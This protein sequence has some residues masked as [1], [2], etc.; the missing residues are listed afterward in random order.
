MQFEK[1]SPVAYG[2]DK[3]LFYPQKSNTADTPSGL[4]ALFYIAFIFL[5]N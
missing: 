5:C 3:R 2:N 1:K 4:S